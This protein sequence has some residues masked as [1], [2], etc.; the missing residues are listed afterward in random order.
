V[1]RSSLVLLL[2]IVLAAGCASSPEPATRTI[3]QAEERA[4]PPAWAVTD[5][6]VGELLAKGGRQLT[7]PQLKSLFERA[8]MEGADGSTTWREMSFPDGKVTGQTRMSANLT[9]DYQGTW[10]IDEQ[11]R[12]CWINDRYAGHTPSCMYYYLLDGRYY[13]SDGG[14]TSRGATLEPRRITR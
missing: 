4:A 1:K 6:T 11:G 14:P 13:A 5:L 12:R 10:W 7:G 2:P 8:V 9:I 3:V